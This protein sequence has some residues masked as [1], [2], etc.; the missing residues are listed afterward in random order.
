MSGQLID[1]STER[2]I[3]LRGGVQA[4]ASIKPERFQL[5]DFDIDVGNQQAICPAGHT[6]TR[7]SQVNGTKNVAFRAFLAN[8]VEIALSFAK[9]PA[10]H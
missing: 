7:W 5:R 8:S 10:Q 9:M 6:S 2:G 1:S 3:D 4:S